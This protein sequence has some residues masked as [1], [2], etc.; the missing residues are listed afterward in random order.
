MDNKSHIFKHLHST[1]CFESYKSLSF[2]TIVKVNSKFDLKI[3]DEFVLITNVLKEYD[4]MKEEIK[5]WK[6]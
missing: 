5:N 6:T 3:N 2:K 4:E 1:T